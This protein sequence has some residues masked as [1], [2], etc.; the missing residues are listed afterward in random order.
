MQTSEQ[1]AQSSDV[2]ELPSNRGALVYILGTTC[3]LGP[4]FFLFDHN[5]LTVIS[6]FGTQGLWIILQALTKSSS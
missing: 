6:Y 5:L 2:F 3:T 4:L 1:S